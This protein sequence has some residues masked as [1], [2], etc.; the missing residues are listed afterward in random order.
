MLALVLAAVLVAQ[1]VQGAPTN[2]GE[3]CDQT[4]G[5]YGQSWGSHSSYSKQSRYGSHQSY[6]SG[7]RGLGATGGR[8][9]TLDE[10][11][12]IGT[13]GLDRP[14]TWQD[15]K[16][17]VTDDGKGEMNY[18]AG[19]TVTNNGFSKYASHSYRYGSHD[20]HAPLS[21]SQILSTSEFNSELQNI[22]SR[23]ANFMGSFNLGSGSLINSNTLED[24]K[25]NANLITTQFNDVCSQLDVNS[26]MYQQMQQELQQFLRQSE[27]RQ[28]QM[29]ATIFQT[30]STTSTATHGSIHRYPVESRPAS[31]VRPDENAIFIQQQQQRIEEEISQIQN[32]INSFYSTFNRVDSDVKFEENLNTEVNVITQKLI[33]LNLQAE[34]NQS[35][36]QRIENMKNRYEAYVSSIRARIEEQVRRNQEEEVKRQQRLQEIENERIRLE[37]AEQ[38]KQAQLRLE[39]ERLRQQELEAERQRHAAEKRR[40]EAEAESRRRL[41][42]LEAE[43][44]KI[45][46]DKINAEERRRQTEKLQIQL[47]QQ[48]QHLQQLQAVQTTRPQVTGS[49]Q[50]SGTSS[51]HHT[52]SGSYGSTGSIGS[53][54]SYGSTGSIGSTGS[55]GS[56]GSTGSTGSYGSTGSSGTSGSYTRPQPLHIDLTA[57]V[58]RLQQDF[59]RIQNEVNKFNTY[60]MRLTAD[61]KVNIVNEAKQR[62]D[63][64]HQN[65]ENIC[66][67]SSRYN[68]QNLLNSAQELQRHFESLYQKFQNEAARTISSD[69]QVSVSGGYTSSSSYGASGSHHVVHQ[70][71]IT[72]VEYSH[73]KSTE[74]EI[75]SSRRP[76]QHYASGSGYSQSS[77]YKSGYGASAD[78][79]YRTGAID[80]GGS[81]Y[82][83]G[84]DCVEQQAGQPCIIPPRRNRRNVGGK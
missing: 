57:A 36:R 84:V 8:L 28:R 26:S 41:Q 43:K 10:N 45:E 67:Q 52:V 6:S 20:S 62:Y 5:S 72:N 31:V 47:D 39:T 11:A 13:P 64:L 12:V 40:L 38:A 76:A 44:Q 49:V 50:V 24:F 42:A 19:Q 71:K 51:L 16:H 81:G 63:Q 9:E 34:Q 21:N 22:R 83:G 27:E 73:E 68:N 3:L 46:N 77:G 80:L 75:G 56:T 14:G 60:T 33:D 61:N 69:S 58:N 29:E 15:E 4:T 32:Q 82:S 59:N 66:N 70:P 48:Q 65:L 25:H 30:A 79:I 2:C 23:I 18:R 53:T 55:Y 17:Y 1:A 78:D 37:N 35:Q 74:V 54:G 7:S